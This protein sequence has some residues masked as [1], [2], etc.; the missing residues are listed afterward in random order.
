MLKRFRRV[1]LPESLHSEWQNQSDK[2]ERG[3]KKRREMKWKKEQE[4]KICS[5]K[6][7]E[8]DV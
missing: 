2:K 5:K 8:N 1:S 7:K 6:G 4:R 3:R